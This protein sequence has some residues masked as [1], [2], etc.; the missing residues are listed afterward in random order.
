[1][2][3]N[4]ELILLSAIVPPKGRKLPLQSGLGVR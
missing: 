4:Q 3:N 2:R 1:V